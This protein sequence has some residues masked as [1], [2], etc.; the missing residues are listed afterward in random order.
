M[1][2]LCIC[3]MCGKPRG[4]NQTNN[5]DCFISCE[6]EACKEIREDCLKKIFL[7]T[8]VGGTCYFC[9]IALALRKRKK[10]QRGEILHGARNYF[11]RRMRWIAGL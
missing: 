5:P 11:L 2:T 8:S 7:N 1:H 6:N 9:R 10:I 4:C 3:V